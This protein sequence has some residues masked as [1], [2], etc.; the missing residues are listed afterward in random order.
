LALADYPGQRRLM[1]R[2]QIR[3]SQPV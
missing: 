2:V 1:H 3:G